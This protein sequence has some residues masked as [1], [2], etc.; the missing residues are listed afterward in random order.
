MKPSRYFLSESLCGLENNNRLFW[1]GV[2]SPSTVPAVLHP[3]IHIGNYV[4]AFCFS[5]ISTLRRWDFEAAALC[6]SFGAGLTTFQ[7]ALPEWNHD[8]GW[9]MSLCSCYQNSA[10]VH[11]CQ[12]E[13]QR[14]NIGWSS[15]ELLYRQREP[16]RTNALKI[17]W[18][19]LEQ[20]VRSFMVFKDPGNTS[21]CTVLRMVGFK[22][23][24][25]A[26]STSC[27]Q[28]VYGLHACCHQFSFGGGC[29]L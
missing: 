27:F 13:T 12:I 1:Y 3:H 28:Q 23:K 18:L 21:S 15:K 19:S 8:L 29:L 14:Q 24:F 16:Q 2:F 25:Q 6:I 9:S 4:K 20:L 17:V 11:L 5:L 22:V 26:L 7:A 10:L